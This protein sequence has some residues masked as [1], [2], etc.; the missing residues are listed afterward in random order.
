MSDK[1]VED[2]L[3]KA[4]EYYFNGMS[5]REAIVKAMEEIKNGL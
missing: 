4:I 2:V 3:Y 5:A 1:E